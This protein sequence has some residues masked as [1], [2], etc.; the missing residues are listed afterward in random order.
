M[1][2]SSATLLTPEI[3]E[4]LPNESLEDCKKELLKKIENREISKKCD[5]LCLRIRNLNQLHDDAEL[6]FNK[7]LFFASE[8][9]I[10]K[11]HRYHKKNEAATK[12]TRKPRLGNS[13]GGLTAEQLGQVD[14]KSGG[15]DS[16]TSRP[17]ANRLVD[18][19]GAGFSI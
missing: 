13:K 18:K 10:K 19:A 5:V 9:I 3:L 7:V 12:Q 16:T 11:F 6:Q 15:G 17:I 8:K 4:S 1:A 14:A 2:G